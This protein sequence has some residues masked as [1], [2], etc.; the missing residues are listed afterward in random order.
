MNRQLDK[1]SA[2]AA[3][4][5]MTIRPSVEGFALETAWRVVVTGSLKQIDNWLTAAEAS[6]LKAVA[7]P[8]VGNSADY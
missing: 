6:D 5:S 4:R 1:L 7:P 3:K 8:A 2:R